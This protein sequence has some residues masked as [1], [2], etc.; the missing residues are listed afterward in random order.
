MS[1]LSEAMSACRMITSDKFRLAVNQLPF[2][3]G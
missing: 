2:A 1:E 3:I